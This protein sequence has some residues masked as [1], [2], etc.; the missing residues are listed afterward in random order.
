MCGQSCVIRSSGTCLVISFSL[1]ISSTKSI[2]ELFQKRVHRSFG[3]IVPDGEPDSPPPLSEQAT[4]TN[5]NIIE[6]TE[7]RHSFT[8]DK[9]G[10]TID[11]RVAGYSGGCKKRRHFGANAYYQ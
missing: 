1:D 9:T 6:G 4:L 5:V 8:T 10:E 11:L 3:F 2:D 7:S